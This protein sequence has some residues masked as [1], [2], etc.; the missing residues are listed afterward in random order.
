MWPFS[1]IRQ[2]RKENADL[3]W[4]L[5]ACGAASHGN[6]AA[7][8]QSTDGYCDPSVFSTSL[9]EVMSLQKRYE[10]LEKLLAQLTNEPL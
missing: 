6:Y 4:Q 1:T 5:F 2:L 10:R 7:F 3:R 9:M 8:T